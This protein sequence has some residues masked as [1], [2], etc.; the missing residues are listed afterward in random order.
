M[1]RKEAIYKF[2][3]LKSL[4]T[5][6]GYQ[7]ERR[8]EYK[9]LEIVDVDI[10]N[11]KNDITFN[12][13]GIYI[14]DKETKQRHQIFLYKRNYRLQM[15]GK[16]RF[17]IRKCKTIQGFINSG[18][19]EAAYRRANT[20][21]VDVCNMDDYLNEEKVSCLPLC[22]Y[23]LQMLGDEYKLS[24]TSTT[25]DFVERLKTSTHNSVEVD[26][27]GYAK[28]WESISKE[29]RKKHSYICDK[30]G[31]Q[32]TNP[33]DLQ[34]IHVHHKNNCKIDNQD[35]NLQCL[36]IRCHSEIDEYHFTRF[37]AGAN[38]VMLEA[39]NIKYPPN[40]SPISHLK[41]DLPF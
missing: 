20:E 36:C 33:F 38:K 37:H 41:D 6:M 22:Q 7:L 34:Y 35:S 40:R 29:F 1:D 27:F 15:Y 13:E 18:T 32:I 11:I 5:E 9:P 12:E 25:H 23:C 28:D 16:P 2:D 30:C 21:I 14:W 19:F 26:I 17:H 4:L 10:S 24:K 39:F 3:G 8:A 31:L